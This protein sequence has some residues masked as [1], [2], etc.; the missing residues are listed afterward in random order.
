MHNCSRVGCGN[1]VVTK[2]IQGVGYV[3]FEC[4]ED[5][6]SH[7]I[8]KG[9]VVDDMDKAISEL[10]EFL[11]EDKEILFHHYIFNLDSFLFP[12]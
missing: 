2:P 7:L 3:C 1:K 11:R 9:I 4:K 6:K 8:R 5:F 12:K 10:K